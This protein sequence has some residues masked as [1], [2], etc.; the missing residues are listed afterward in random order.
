MG[1]GISYVSLAK[2][3]LPV[4]IKDVSN[5]GVLNAFNYNYKLLEKQRK[6]RILSKANAQAKMLQ[7]TGGIDFTHFSKVD[8][9]MEAVF[10]D[11]DLISEESSL[12][13]YFKN[14]ILFSGWILF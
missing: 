1:A 11:L 2:A 3:K 5:D 12:G 7:L 9:V 14:W 4:T 8:V 10:E 13:S 6:R